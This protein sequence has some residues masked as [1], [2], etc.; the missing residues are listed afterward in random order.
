MHCC[1]KSHQKMS[2]PMKQLSLPNTA[3]W[4]VADRSCDSDRI[5]SNKWLCLY[6]SVHMLTLTGILD[7]VLAALLLGAHRSASA[8]VASLPDSVPPLTPAAADLSDVC[9]YVV[10]TTVLNALTLASG[11][12]AMVIDAAS[13]DVRAA[14]SCCCCCCSCDVI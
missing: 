10:M 2:K 5:P 7:D 12:V 9:L 4:K 11:C 1:Y 14:S 3:Q 13:V 6:R 8:G